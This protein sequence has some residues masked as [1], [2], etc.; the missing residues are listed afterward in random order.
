MHQT[1]HKCSRAYDNRVSMIFHTQISSNTINRIIFNQKICYVALMQ[2]QAV[3]AFQFKL[4]SKLVSF[5][6]TLSSWRSDTGPL[7]CVQHS[8]L[9]SG[10]ISVYSHY[11]PKS[12]YFSDHVSFPKPSDSGIAGH[13]TYRI[14]ILSNHGNIATHARGSHGRLDSRVAGTND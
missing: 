7:S 14:K 2:I 11:S 13:L 3:L 6:I 8:K 9:N 4:H 10:R 12:I 5:F 1:A